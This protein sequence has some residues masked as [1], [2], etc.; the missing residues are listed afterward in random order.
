MGGMSASTAN[1]LRFIEYIHVAAKQK[2]LSDKPPKKKL[3]QAYLNISK[4]KSLQ[5]ITNNTFTVIGQ[6]VAEWQRHYDCNS[7]TSADKCM[8]K[9]LSNR[10]R[11][12]Q[13]SK[14]KIK[15]QDRPLEQQEKNYLEL[16]ICQLTEINQR[17]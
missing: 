1:C 7:K 13:Q 10:P 8:N 6:G 17:R 9:D 2:E 16:P 3:I 12:L 15:L 4:L 5:M 14:M 11:M